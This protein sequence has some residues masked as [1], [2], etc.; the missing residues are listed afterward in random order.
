MSK[1]KPFG[2]AAVMAAALVAFAVP[3]ASATTLGLQTGTTISA[4]AEGTTIL[5]PPIG[6]IEC[7]KSSVSGKTTNEGGATETV[8]GNIEALS[9]TECNATVTVLAKG[10]LEVHTREATEN[11]NG[12]LTSSGTE[13][14][15][16]FAGFHCIFKTSSTDIGTFTG[17]PVSGGNATF[18]IAATIPRTGG[19]SGAFCGSTAAWTGSY[20]VTSPSPLAVDRVCFQRG[21]SEGDYKT[22]M[23]CNTKENKKEN[24]GEWWRRF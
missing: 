20:N 7:K 23:D 1:L 13:V 24:E 21:P 12:T 16:E 5:H 17:S 15:V 22:E 8:K 9:F 4:E 10:S 3:T 19:R 18:D 14:T 2:A 11:G 6:D